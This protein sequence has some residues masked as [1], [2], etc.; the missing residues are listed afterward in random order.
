MKIEKVS[1][2]MIPLEQYATVFEDATLSAVVQQRLISHMT[3]PKSNQ[4]I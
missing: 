4:W 2:L 1:D 3:I